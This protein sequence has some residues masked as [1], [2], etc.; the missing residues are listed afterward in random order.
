MAGRRTDERGPADTTTCLAGN[1]AARRRL[2]VTA[3]WEY[4]SDEQEVNG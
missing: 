3:E 1:V 4:G 2:T